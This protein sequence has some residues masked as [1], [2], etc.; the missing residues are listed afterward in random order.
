M[1]RCR[2]TQILANMAFVLLYGFGKVL[3]TIFLGQLRPA[4]VEVRA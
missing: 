4:E 1:G 3:K 2:A